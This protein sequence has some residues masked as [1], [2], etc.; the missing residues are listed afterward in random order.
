MILIGMNVNGTPIHMRTDDLPA[1]EQRA[2]HDAI[3]VIRKIRND[4][5]GRPVVPTVTTV[6]SGF[7]TLAAII[8]IAPRMNIFIAFGII[9]AVMAAIG[10]IARSRSLKIEAAKRAADVA[11][12][13]GLVR[14]SVRARE[15]VRD[16]I[17]ASP[18]HKTLLEKGGVQLINVYA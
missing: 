4:H 1:N 6:A 17:A 3:A 7:I 16:V 18:E 10:F 14:N 15:F 11:E 9:G 2:A 13:N 8:F 12:L 5:E